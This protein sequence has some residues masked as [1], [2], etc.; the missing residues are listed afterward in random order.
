MAKEDP[1]G[2]TGLVLM[3]SFLGDKIKELREIEVANL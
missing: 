3:T 1:N 2:T